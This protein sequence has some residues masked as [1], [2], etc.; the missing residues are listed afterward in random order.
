MIGWNISIH[1]QNDGGDHPASFNSLYGHSLA[2]WQTGLRGCEW[3]DD[4]VQR[5]RAVDLGGNGYPSRYT[6]KAKE[7]VPMLVPKPPFARDVWHYD[8]GDILTEK[9][10]GKTF[11]DHQGLAKCASEEWLLIE[12][13]DES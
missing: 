3:L 1:R 4:L 12:V 7:I 13:W 6:S 9:W 11:M 2:V 8:P 5:S 10:H